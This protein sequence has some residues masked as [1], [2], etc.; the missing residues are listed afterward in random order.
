M[1]LCGI[2]ELDGRA[3]SGS[4]S[5]PLSA[6]WNVSAASSTS[7]TLGASLAF[8]H[9]SLVAELNATALEAGIEHIFTLT[10]ANFLGGVGEASVK[11]TRM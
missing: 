3:S 5:R 11:V 10:A 8:F 4:L 1:G 2:L 6:F 9:G 7:E